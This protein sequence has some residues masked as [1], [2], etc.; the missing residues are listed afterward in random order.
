MKE[1]LPRTISRQTGSY[2]VTTTHDEE[3][4]AFV[5]FPLPPSD[6]PL[7]VAGTMSALHEAALTSLARLGVAGS[8]VPSTGWFLYGFVRKEAVIT[9][10]IEGT[11]ATLTDVLTFEA[12]QM[13]D[14]PA[15]VEEV[16][17]DVDAVAYARADRER[18]GAPAQRSI[19]MRHAQDSH[20]WRERRG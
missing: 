20:A 15:D 5:P 10:Q 18:E 6:P 12:T 9:S 2:Q 13:T 19:V 8:M 11:Q 1:P 7:D 14:R 17:N 4:R 16:C 3:V